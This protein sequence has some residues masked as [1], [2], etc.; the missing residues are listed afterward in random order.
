M[1]HYKNAATALTADIDKYDDARC[2]LA[3]VKT[4]MGNTLFGM[5]KVSEA[6][7][8]YAKALEIAKLPFSVEHGPSSPL[9][10]RRRIC[11]VGR[12]GICKITPTQD[13][14]A[15][16]QLLDAARRSYEKCLNVWKQ[17]PN[18]SRLSGN[19]YATGD[20]KQI[21]ASLQTCRDNALLRAPCQRFRSLDRDPM[22]PGRPG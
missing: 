13:R 3:M 2:D 4:K 15:Q 11:R 10:G 20:P 14:A 6:S 8:N 9:R 18:P 12:G 16:S 1:K 5:G 7:E 21:A 17:I 19:G 22:R